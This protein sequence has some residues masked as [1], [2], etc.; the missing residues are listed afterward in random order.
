MTDDTQ[1]GTRTIVIS[2][3]TDGM[4]RALALGRLARGDTVV[5]IG[6]NAA[7]GAA[8][9]REAGTSRLTYLRADLSSIAENR[10]VAA[11]ITGR[12]PAVDAL[13]L[14]ANRV[15]KYRRETVDGLES[16]FATYYLSRHLLSH[17]LLPA[18]AAAP[19]P[20]IVSVAGVGATAG[21]VSW[22]DMQLTRQY[23]MV[24]AQLHGGRCTDLLG[25]AFAR[26][27]TRV[28][29]VMYH[30]GFTR[31]GDTSFLNPV[32]KTVM[33]GLRVFAKP[34]AKSVA[35]IHDW[36]DRPPATPLT[37]DD[38]GKPVD[39]SLK[40]LDPGDAARLADYT[41]E[42]LRTVSVRKGS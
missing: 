7:K 40:T 15:A 38:R 33:Y 36:I 39:P 2:G 26:E 35:P 5:A 23:G 8:L 1:T 41:A 18:L 9:T 22:D 11:E 19:R 28:P 20:V 4:G 16:V 34:I 17:A 31:S 30:P 27:E 3:G 25:V 14:F 29:F 37:A 24:A 42:L 6:S 13:A 10:R 32:L 12:F 21:A